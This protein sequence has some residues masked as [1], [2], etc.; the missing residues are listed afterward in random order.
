MESR[1]GP[2]ATAVEGDWEQVLTAIR[3]CHQAMREQHPRIIT[4]ITIDDR[5]EEPHYLDEMINR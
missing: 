3:H 1:L 5:N 2:L 4:T